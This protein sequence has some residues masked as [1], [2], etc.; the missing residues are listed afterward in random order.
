MRR[1][2][3]WITVSIA[4]IFLIAGLSL[5]GCG[6]NG[7]AAAGG[8]DPPAV[9]GMLRQVRSASEL[10]A[11]L[12]ASLQEMVANGTAAGPTA[13][14]SID[15]SSFSNTNT[16]EAG[17]DEFDSVRYDGVHLYIAPSH[18]SPGAIRIVRTNA[19]IGTAT[20]VSTIPVPERE[21][22]QGMYA[23]NGRLL[24]LS[25]EAYFLPF[26]PLWSSVLIWAP[27]H[28]TIRVYDVDDAAQPRAIFDAEIDGVFVASRRIDDR[29]YLVSRHTPSLLIDPEKRATLASARLDELL[30]RLRVGGRERP[31]VSPTDCYVT[32][33]ATRDGYP[34]ITTISML[35]LQNPG[36][37]VS[38]CYNEPADGVY[39]SRTALYV[40]QPRVAPGGASLTRVHKFA[41]AN[42]G[43]E[44][45]GSVEVAGNVWSGGQSDF[46]MNEHEGMLRVLT[47]EWTLEPGDAIDH[48][49]F[50]L[51]QKAAEPALEIV[52]R[53]PNDL[54]PAEIGKPNERLFGVRFTGDRAYGITFEIIDPLYVF[55]LSNP[56]DP[57][58]A[59]EL[60]VPGVSDY[61]HP[62][63]DDLLLGLGANA[64]QVKVE[65]FDVSVLE[66][67][68]SRGAVTLGGERSYSEA[69]YDRHAFTYLDGS[70]DRLAFPATTYTRDADD[71]M[72]AQTS[73]H[74]FE[75]LGEGVPS[76]AVLRDAGTVSPPA[77]VPADQY[78]ATGRSFID[79]DHVWY[80]RNGHVWSSS[81]L[82]PGAVRGPF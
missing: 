23:A 6:G 62:I 1:P 16:V 46:R 33:D 13:A 28:M 34:V 64:G 53:L 19:A 79:G 14:P 66:H 60:E 26:G 48:R 8:Q 54:R 70:P 5:S 57:R 17:V 29:V 59:G 49:L 24:V 51:R 20:E 77:V 69:T 3:N 4:L 63:G 40:S 21:F 39:A 80:V 43:P 7:P 9:S 75:V 76:T 47:S 15:V 61:L 22:V 31:A 71:V 65:L 81:W 12:K 52:G 58:I 82:A 32:N 36:A 73:L 74:Q 37:L 78:S 45:S 50:V 44:Y 10:E 27:T 11:S 55:D 38:K 67:P 68:Q 25:S 2:I 41:F 56:A 30:P 72:Q 18:A 42:S 35:S